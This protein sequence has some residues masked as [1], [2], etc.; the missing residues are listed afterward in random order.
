MGVGDAHSSRSIAAAKGLG[1][2]IRGAEK[3]FLEERGELSDSLLLT[4]WSE[5]RR[6]LKSHLV[7]ASGSRSF[8]AKLEDRSRRLFRISSSR[9]LVA[10]LRLIKSVALSLLRRLN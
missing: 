9:A 5:P 7:V 2:G 10:A 1:L 8:A 3:L 4:V 6:E